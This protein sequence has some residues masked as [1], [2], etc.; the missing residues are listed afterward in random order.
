MDQ[1]P[2]SAFSEGDVRLPSHP[3]KTGF[4]AH[5]ESGFGWLNEAMPA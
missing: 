1:G 5:A 2:G 4:Y 3:R